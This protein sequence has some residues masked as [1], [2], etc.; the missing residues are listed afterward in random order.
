LAIR[1][2]TPGRRPASYSANPRCF[3]RNCNLLTA[4][5]QT[6]H[7]AFKFIAFIVIVLVRFFG[8]QKHEARR[9]L[10]FPGFAGNSSLTMTEG[11][12]VVLPESGRTLPAIRVASCQRQE[13]G[14]NALEVGR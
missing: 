12:S 5:A 14:A 10:D 2:G 9:S 6:R 13:T 4:G 11:Y 7:P 3:R 8:I 1:T